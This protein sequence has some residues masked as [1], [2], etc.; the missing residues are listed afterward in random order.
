VDT[1]QSEDGGVM[2]LRNV[3]TNI[4]IHA[5]SPRRRQA[6]SLFEYSLFE[7]NRDEEPVFLRV[8]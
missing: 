1:N 4:E 7:E 8:T 3:G 5:A 2:F 6:I